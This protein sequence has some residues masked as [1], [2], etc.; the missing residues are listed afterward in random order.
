ME[1]GDAEDNESEKDGSVVPADV[2]EGAPDGFVE[3]SVEWVI[4]EERDLDGRGAEEGTHDPGELGSD[5]GVTGEPGDKGG[6]G[7][8]FVGGDGDEEFG[9]VEIGNDA[10]HGDEEGVGD[11][12]VGVGGGGVR[13]VGRWGV[14]RH[15]ECGRRK[16][17][18][19][20]GGDGEAD[21]LGEDG[22]AKTEAASEEESEHAVE[23]TVACEG[24][25]D[26]GGHFKGDEEA[27]LGCAPEA[28]GEA[29]TAEAE[30]DGDDA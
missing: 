12:E 17:A 25:E 29:I 9:E 1:G 18:E 27:H 13:G 28:N 15:E 7:D 5:E 19:D 26:E 24:E 16:G 3:G 14:E 20:E 2:L 22:L 8:A 30:E 6:G 4:A 23:E 10:G 11:E 21:E